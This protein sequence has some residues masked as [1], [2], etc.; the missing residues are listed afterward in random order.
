MHT[1]FVGVAQIDNLAAPVAHIWFF[2]AMPSRLGALLAIK[3]TSMEKV[4][5]F[6]DYIVVDP[7]DTP[8]ARERLR[9]R[10]R[11]R[12]GHVQQIVLAQGRHDERRV[13]PAPERRE[14]EGALGA[15]ACD[16]R[17]GG[18]RRC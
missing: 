12:P 14:I 7:G 13:V 17:V 6:Q 16:D 15:G 1:A 4:I 11:N 2:K 3:T 18:S 8:R 9:D 5:Y 10:T